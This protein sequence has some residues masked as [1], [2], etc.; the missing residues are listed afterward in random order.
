[1][2][3]IKE[4]IASIVPVTL[5]FVKLLPSGQTIQNTSS[6]SITTTLGEDK[7][8]EML[9]ATTLSD[10]AMSASVK[11]G[12]IGQTYFV[13]FTAIT[14]SYKWVKKVDLEIVEVL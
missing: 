7:T 5:D 14:Q 8:A 13:I 9:Q 11:S 12:A 3:R 2:K 6:I 4:G 1:M 10:T